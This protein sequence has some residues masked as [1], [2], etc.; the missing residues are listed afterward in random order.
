MPSIAENLQTLQTIKNNIKTSIENKGVDVGDVSFTE[1]S[2]KIDEITTGGGGDVSTRV[3]NVTENG[4]YTTSYSRISDIT[5]PDLPISGYY[6]NDDIPFYGYANTKRSFLT[7]INVDLSTRIE[8]WFI[9]NGY[10]T[11]NYTKDCENYVGAV[12]DGRLTSFGF[13]KSYTNKGENYNARI[14]NEKIYVKTEKIKQNDFN[15]IVMSVVDG[16][17]VNDEKIGDFSNPT[18]ESNLSTIRIGGGDISA[19]YKIGVVK[20]NN[21]TFLATP[22]GF[23][24]TDTNTLLTIYNTNYSYKYEEPYVVPSFDG[25]LYRT[26]KVNTKINMAK[27]GFKFAYN[28][29]VTEIP[30]YADWSGITDMSHMFQGCTKLESI[31]L[32]DTSNVTD[33]QYMFY[34]CS[35]LQTIPFLNTSNVMNMYA[36][37]QGC[38]KLTTI[39][40][41]DT[42]NVTNM[43]YMF[44]DCK[45]LTTIPQLNTSKTTNVVY[46]FFGCAKLQSLPLLDFGSISSSLNINYVFSPSITTLTDLG[47]FKNLKINWSD[48]YGLYKLPNLTYESVMNVINNLYDF[49]GNGDTSTTRTIKFNANSKALLSDA[50]IAIATSKGWVIS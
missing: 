43:R 47:G 44:Q 30:D 17:W 11:T 12:V 10:T 37:F 29:Y 27:T 15:H 20:I 33:M 25:N 50:D 13:E 9:D 6:P 48:N 7:D 14:G 21:N 35:N 28:T 45:L 16:L 26:V 34:D 49:R 32:I 46:M 36:M 40:Q 41:L 31:P 4:E 38:S 18:I 3:L 24:N 23:I 19:N 8:F 1:Y 5:L 39:P 42:S 2:T 22:D